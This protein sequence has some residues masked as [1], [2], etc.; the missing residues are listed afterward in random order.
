MAFKM[1]V[2]ARGHLTPHFFFETKNDCMINPT[3]FLR[4]GRNE[5]KPVKITPYSVRKGLRPILAGERSRNTES[6]YALSASIA[7]QAL[8]LLRWI[9]FKLS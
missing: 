7:G 2:V 1:E 4:R 8:L 5:A 6:E 3:N 9:L